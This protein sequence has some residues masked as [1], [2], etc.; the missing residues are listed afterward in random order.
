[1][2]EIRRQLREDEKID[3]KGAE[4]KVRPLT[5]LEKERTERGKGIL[6]RRKGEREGRIREERTG[7]INL[8]PEGR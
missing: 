8:V 1:M 6:R 3:K 7:R 5:E 4:R 2:K